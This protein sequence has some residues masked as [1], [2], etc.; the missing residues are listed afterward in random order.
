MSGNGKGYNG[1]GIFENIEGK[2]MLFA[3]DDE[4]YEYKQESEEEENG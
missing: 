2:L 1:Y 3:T 4:A